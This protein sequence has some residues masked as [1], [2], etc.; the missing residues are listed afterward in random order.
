MEIKN[1]SF[2]V[3]N[4]D[5]GGIENYLLRF[6]QYKHSEF[7]RIYIY[8]KS[9][10]GGQLENDY[11]KI[12]NVEIVKRKHSYFN[13]F[14]FIWMNDFFKR[15]DVSVVCDFTGNFAGLPVTVAVFANVKKRI[16]FY[17]SAM[18]AFKQSFLKN[19]YSKFVKHL[20]FKFST[21][22]LSNSEAAFDYFYKIDWRNNKRFKVIH[23]GINADAFIQTT[24][25][26]RAE[27]KIPNDAFVIGHTGRY[28]QAKN[29]QT[30]LNVAFRLV[31]K[32]PDIYFLFCGNGVKKSLSDLVLSEGLDGRILLFENR[33][34]IPVFLN[35]LDCYFFPSTREGQPNALIEAMIMGLPFIASDIPPIRETVGDNYTL[36][37]AMDVDALAAAIEKE[38][39]DRRGR[40]AAL[41]QEMFKRFDYN[42]R[43][44]EFYEVLVND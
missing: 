32:Y 34:D 14:S 30:I 11:L 31:R 20:T 38:Y 13:I 12:P 19:L 4:L 16:V 41:Q 17:R 7:N 44:N 8:C 18:D 2:L 10:S 37:P 27:L 39:F 6:L 26:L 28:N 1:I 3:N 43:F 9:G 23:N 36:Y 35:T 42:E 25:N 5:S 40:N 29:H 22:I 21:T 24:E 15:K 33:T